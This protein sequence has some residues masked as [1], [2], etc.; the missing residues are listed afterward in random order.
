MAIA[1]DDLKRLLAYSTI[2]QVGYVF[3]GIGLGTYLGVYGGIFHAVTHL[4][5][6][7]LLFFC[8]GAIIYRLGLRRISDLGGLSRKMPLTAA[9]FFVGCLSIGGLP[10]FAGFPSK[11]TIVLALAQA[12]LWWAL[13]ITAFAGHAD[14]R[15][16]RLG[17]LP[18]VLGRGVAEGRGTAGR[19]PRAAAV[20]GGADDRAGGGGRS[21][22]AS[23]RSCST[24][25]STAACDRSSASSSREV[26]P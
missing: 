24:R 19:R 10:F 8:S 14:A 17:R 4:L 9:C 15:G 21:C 13:A 11:Y 3:I 7:A 26:A 16:A 20:D 18:G 2:S 1:Q 25:C 22:W 6:K 5:A 12:Q 23:T